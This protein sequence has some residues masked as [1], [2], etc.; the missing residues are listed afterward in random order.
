[1]R[2][3]WTTNTAS[4]YAMCK[5]DGLDQLYPSEVQ[6]LN[7]ALIIPCSTAS[8]ERGFSLM[9]SLCTNLRN[10]LSQSSLD[11]LMKICREGDKELSNDCLEDLVEMFKNKKN[12]KIDL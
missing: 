7:F 4:L 2:R 10:R 9:N 1:M 6:L 12:R 5:R 11:S 8:V 3:L